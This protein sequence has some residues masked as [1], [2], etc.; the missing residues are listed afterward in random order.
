MSQGQIQQ[1]KPVFKIQFTCSYDVVG[2][3]DF[4]VFRDELI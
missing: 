2:E 1:Q 3:K 4:P